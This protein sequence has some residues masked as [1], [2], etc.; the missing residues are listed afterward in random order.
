M[1]YLSF[2]WA[3]GAQVP[4]APICIKRVE[5]EEGLCEVSLFIHSTLQEGLI[6]NIYH[7]FWTGSFW[8]LVSH[9]WAMLSEKQPSQNEGTFLW[10]PLCQNPGQRERAYNLGGEWR[11]PST[12]NQKRSFYKVGE[13]K[14]FAPLAVINLKHHLA[15]LSPRLAH[16]LFGKVSTRK[17]FATR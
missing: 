13:R 5:H 6:E 8:A 11:N 2:A 15:P 12:S 16:T 4:S 1:I 10:R 14:S 3:L 7:I 9:S 17:P